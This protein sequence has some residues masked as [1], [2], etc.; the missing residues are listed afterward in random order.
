MGVADKAA[1]VFVSLAGA[2]PAILS[3][4]SNDMTVPVFGV[5]V[6]TIGGAALGTLAA[7]AYDNNPPRP[8]GRLAVRSLGTII[9]ASLLVGGVPAIAGWS[10][11]AQAAEGAVA[12]LTALVV[13]YVF[14][15]LKVWALAQLS[16]FKLSDFIPWLRKRTPTPPPAG[17]NA[18]TDDKGPTP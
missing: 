3:S 8:G 15:P 11:N 10:W 12:G 9:M 14:D 2:M 4:F 17:Q 5:G 7:I 6:T 16:E 1:G 18:P 13:Y